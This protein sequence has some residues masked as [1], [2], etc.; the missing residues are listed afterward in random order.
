M[1][2][3]PLDEPLDE[4]WSDEEDEDDWPEDVVPEL[5]VPELVVPELVLC[6][7]ATV[8]ALASEARCRPRP[9]A[10]SVVDSSTPAVQRRVVRRARGVADTGG[11]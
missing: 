9:P 5:V 3:K 2:P 7:E 1:L 6:D 8:A 10:T 11:S 4:D